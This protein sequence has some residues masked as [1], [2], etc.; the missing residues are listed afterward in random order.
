MQEDERIWRIWWDPQRLGEERATK[1]H[2]K[3]PEMIYWIGTSFLITLGTT[4]NTS[5]RDFMG[6]NYLLSL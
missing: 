1:M 3:N 4:Q 6:R 5:E 2:K